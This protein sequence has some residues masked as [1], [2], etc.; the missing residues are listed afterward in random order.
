MKVLG[1]SE[2]GGREVWHLSV[3]GKRRDVI[4]TV[5]SLKAMEEAVVLYAATLKRLADR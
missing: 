5:S 4:T 1:K 2:S 3:N